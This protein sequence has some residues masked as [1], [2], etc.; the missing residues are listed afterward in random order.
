MSA[1]RASASG[2]AQDGPEGLE[3]EIRAEAQLLRLLFGHPP[4][5][6]G[7][8]QG[9]VSGV[10]HGGRDRPDTSWQLCKGL[11]AAGVVGQVDDTLPEEQR[12]GTS[13]RGQGGARYAVSRAATAATARGSDQS[14]PGRIAPA[15]MTDCWLGGADA[16]LE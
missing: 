11:G 12:E 14:L 5:A 4:M 8:E 2:S 16:A 3:G 9:S 1:R 15:S 10:T 6:C 7:R 13:S